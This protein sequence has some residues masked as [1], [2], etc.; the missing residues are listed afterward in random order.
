MS[1]GQRKTIN[2][3]YEDRNA[4][5]VAFAL[6][7]DHQAGWHEP[8]VA[9]ADADQWAIVWVDTPEGQ[10]S[11]HVPKEIAST[12]RLPEAGKHWDGH[13]RTEKNDRLKALID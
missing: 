9:D 3:V 13:D 7:C 8:E 12:S 2:Q 11:W 10:V 1:D 6:A 5:A 4:L